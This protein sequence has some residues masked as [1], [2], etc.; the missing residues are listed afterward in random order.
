MAARN[1]SII[2]ASASP[3]R[4]K[5]L[6]RAGL[7]FD[8]E[9]SSVDEK[10]VREALADETSGIEPGDFAEVLAR[11][12]AEDVARMVDADIVI[13]AD[14]V[15]SMDGVSYAKAES[16]AE[17]RNQLLAFKGK[18]HQLHSAVAIVNEGTFTW[19]HVEDVTVH[20]RD[21]SSAF[22]GKYLAAAGE[23]VLQSVGCYQL[24][25]LG[26]QLIDAVDGDYFSVLGLPL[27]ALLGELRRQGLIAT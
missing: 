20:M 25:G 16:I 12:K 17:A 6:E 3:V 7:I 8:V 21:Y 22:V 23:E 1:R 10:V 15:L 19:A 4:R 14:Q 2:L 18:A 9:V 24:E 26:V 5:L 13:G 27:F 11:A